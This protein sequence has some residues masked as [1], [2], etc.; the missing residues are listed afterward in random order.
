MQVKCI[1]ILTKR[2]YKIRINL[3]ITGI[4]TGSKKDGHVGL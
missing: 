4:E 1:K 3:R 2:K